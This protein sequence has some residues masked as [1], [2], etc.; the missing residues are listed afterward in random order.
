M[1]GMGEEV[2]FWL[3]PETVARFRDRSPDV[4][5]EAILDETEDLSTFATLDLGCAGGRNGAQHRSTDRGQR[6][7]LRRGLLRSDRSTRDIPVLVVTAH[8]S[9]ETRSRASFASADAFV[10]KPF[11][12][13]HFRKAVVSLLGDG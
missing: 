6:T 2:G 4:D 5:L 3:R 9:A 12:L 13:N 11:D 1:T 8:D 10:G 7:R